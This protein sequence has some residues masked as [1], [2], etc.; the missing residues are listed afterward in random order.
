MTD[1]IGGSA[2]SGLGWTK[3][4]MKKKYIVII[5]LI[6]CVFVIVFILYGISHGKSRYVEGDNIEVITNRFTSIIKCY[7]EVDIVSDGGIGPTRYNMKVLVNVSQEESARLKEKYIWKT[8]QIT[9]DENLYMGIGSDPVS[10]WQYSKEFCSDT[11]GGHF[12]GEVY[13]SENANC[14]YLIASM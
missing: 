13:F 5:L 12:V 7:Y 3:R 8:V 1:S 11:L 2:V 14:I 6:L 9:V 10:D 4:N